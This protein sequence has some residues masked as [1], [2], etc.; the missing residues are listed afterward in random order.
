[1][2]VVLQIIAYILAYLLWGAIFYLLISAYWEEISRFFVMSWN[3]TT[4][5]F[6]TMSQGGT[7]SVVM[8][9]LIIIIAVSLLLG[10][11]QYLQD[12]GHRPLVCKE[13]TIAGPVTVRQH[14][15]KPTK[16]I[17]EKRR[18]KA[19]SHYEKKCEASLKNLFGSVV[20]FI[21]PLISHPAEDDYRAE[22]D[23]ARNTTEVDLSAVNTKG[24]FCFECKYH[25]DRNGEYV[26]QWHD[27]INGWFGAGF[28]CTFNNSGAINPVTQN[29][30][31]TDAVR[32]FFGAGNI[33]VRNI[34]LT[35][36]KQA[37]FIDAFG[38]ERTCEQHIL[39]LKY[40]AG[41]DGVLVLTSGNWEKELAGYIASLPDVM[42]EADV[43][44]MQGK[45]S[46]L[47]ELK[48]E[49]MEKHLAYVSGNGAPRNEPIW[50][51]N[52]FRQGAE[53]PIE[54]RWFEDMLSRT[55]RT[56]DDVVIKYSDG[57]IDVN[58]IQSNSSS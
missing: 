45:F 12:N 43:L 47:A 49:F 25:F 52:L 21:V 2:V 24:I 6:T 26:F 31:H 46:K 42:S 15:H 39:D 11:I 30:L 35:N 20:S 58:N 22:L 56:P 55:G 1:M 9:A 51:I 19:G 29:T 18:M 17:S 32:T 27:D 14:R 5:Q 10:I 16:E 44:A 23:N 54:K 28:E 57:Y 7:F 38:I 50:S 13:T 33:P 48:P 4:E 8:N 36:A 34:V 53:Y 41:I 3:W 37:T 40:I